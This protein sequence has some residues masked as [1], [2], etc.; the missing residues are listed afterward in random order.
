MAGI[1]SRAQMFDVVP[2]TLKATAGTFDAEAEAL[3]EA[4]LALRRHLDSLGA[5]WGDDVVGARFGGQYL[6]AT[7]TVGANLDALMMGLR[8]ISS[9]LG[10]MA[11]AYEQTDDSVV[12]TVS[13]RPGRTPDRGRL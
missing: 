9:A 4:T 10:A 1:D 7:A 13:D 3:A 6:P 2:A 5:S 12:I 11:S 8:R